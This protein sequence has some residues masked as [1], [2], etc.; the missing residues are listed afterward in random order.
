[1]LPVGPSRHFAASDNLVAI[2]DIA[3]FG[4]TGAR[5]PVRVIF[6]RRG[7]SCLPVHVG[8]VPKA[9]ELP[10]CREGTKGATSGQ[11]DKPTRGR[12]KRE[13]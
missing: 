10:R 8:F 9:T 13:I 2:G 5:S 1:M 7:Q 4:P 6:D 3:D 12:D 11:N